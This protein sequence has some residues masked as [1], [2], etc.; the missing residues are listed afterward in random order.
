MQQPLGLSI[1]D[2]DYTDWTPRGAASVGERVLALMDD[3]LRLVMLSV[4]SAGLL[5]GVHCAV[6]CGGIVAAVSVHR[7]RDRKPLWYHLAYN[8]GRLSSYAAAGAIVGALG[9]SGLLLKG[10]LPVQQT[11]FALASLM[12][13]AMGLQLAG[14]WQGVRRI[15]HLGA[16]LWKS[17]QP[18]SRKLLPADTLAK[19]YALGVLWGWLPCGLVYSV[20]AS[21]LAMGD[22]RRGALVMLAFGVGTLPNL[23][24]VG[25]FFG[26]VQKFARSRAVRFVAG[27]LVAG[28]G[29]YGLFK[30]WTTGLAGWDAFCMQPA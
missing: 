10:I 13:L 19:T 16:A 25:Y 18:Y 1:P 26:G 15:E 22:A 7:P 24:G 20:L 3:Y 28:F 17:I 23:L 27:S 9:R 11:L 5:S 14:I 2:E 30:L 4:F 21:A 6:M 12:L 29:A 8:S